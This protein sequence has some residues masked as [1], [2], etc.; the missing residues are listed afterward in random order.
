MEDYSIIIESPVLTA[1]YVL[2][3]S[4]MAPVETTEHWNKYHVEIPSDNISGPGK[5]DLWV[6]VEYPGS[7]Y[8]NPLGVPN[9][10]EGDSLVLSSAGKLLSMTFRLSRAGRSRG[11]AITTMATLA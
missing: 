11:E 1:P 5:H 10:A 9:S 6:I 3:D 2:N 8:S 4:E 7:D